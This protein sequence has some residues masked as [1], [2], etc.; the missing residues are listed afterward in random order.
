MLLIDQ[1]GME[2]LEEKGSRQRFASPSMKIWGPMFL[3]CE[4]SSP[5]DGIGFGNNEKGGWEGGEGIGGEA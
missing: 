3:A 5:K 1:S 2:S 4:L